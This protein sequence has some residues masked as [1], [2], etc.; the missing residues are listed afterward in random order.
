MWRKQI[1]SS[2]DLKRARFKPLIYSV[3]IVC[4]LAVVCVLFASRKLVRN[5]TDSLPHGIYYVSKKDTYSRGDIV[6]FPVPEEVGGMVIDRG[7]LKEGGVLLKKIAAL[8]GDEV[9]VE[10]STLTINS[11]PKAGIK[12]VDSQGRPLPKYESC[13]PLGKDEIF[14]LHPED[15]ESFDSRYFGPVATKEIKGAAKPLWIF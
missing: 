3:L 1:I 6:S 15:E 4:L 13:G 14:L 7:W 11:E 8:P 10:G 2:P 5:S 12:S 9:C